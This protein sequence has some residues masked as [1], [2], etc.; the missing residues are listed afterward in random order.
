M[1]IGQQAR[2]ARF[3]ALEAPGEAVDLLWRLLT[4][5]Q[6]AVALILGLA[7][8][9]V[10]GTAV[11]QAPPPALDDPEQ[12]RL[13]LGLAREKYGPFTELF[14]GLGLFRVYSVIWF[15]LLVALLAASL[16]ISTINRAP[17]IWAQVRR[18]PAVR[19]AAGFFDHAPLAASTTL[20]RTAVLEARAGLEGLLARH[21]FQVRAEE[22][23]GVV[24]LVAEK[25]SAMRLATLVHHAGLIVVLLSAAA[26]GGEAFRESQFLIPVGGER[27][28][29]HGTEL[30]IRL[31]SFADEYY[32]GAGAVPRDYRSEIDVLKDGK[33]VASGAARVN[34]P[35]EYRGI[36]IHQSYY[37]LAASMWVT[38]ADG[39]DLFR[40]VV[41]LNWRA[42]ERPAGSLKLPEAGL[43]VFVLAPMS[44]KRDPII[45]PGEVRLEVYP[46]GGSSPLAFEH[47]KQGESKVIAGLRF[48]FER[49]TRFTGL[50]LLR[51]P[52]MQLVWLGA[53]MV[54]LGAGAALLLP[55]RRL[56]ARIE[57]GDGGGAVVRLASTRG[58]GL[59][60][61]HEFRVLREHL[62]SRQG[63]ATEAS[64]A[65]APEARDD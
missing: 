59:P 48:G 30:T 55:H 44:S 41:P 49:E 37:G 11:M 58:R 15:R 31:N 39:R 7:F 17:H 32:A 40:D 61:D 8:A 28:V 64:R 10:V 16:L 46:L 12:Y 42:E 29:G 25:N 6:F 38:D 26:G 3:A 53:A 34:H 47:L 14:D 19:A 27:A 1:S 23:E 50:Q 52:G 33:V 54:I 60:F 43:E 18:R 57:A 22:A 20:P 35:F 45:E 2:A 65:R 24:N 4:S 51:D 36:R 5:V 56:W 13:W 63:A 9:A 62:E 21:R